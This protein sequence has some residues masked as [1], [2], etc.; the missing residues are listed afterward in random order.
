M[1]ASGSTVLTEK[2]PGRI[3]GPTAIKAATLFWTAPLGASAAALAEELRRLRNV[4][5]VGIVDRDGKALGIVR[6]GELFGLLSKPFGR[7]ILGRMPVGELMEPSRCFEATAGLFEVA[8]GLLDAD[9]AEK[10]KFCLLVD[11][12]GAFEGVLSAKDLSAYLAG[13]TREDIGLAEIG[14]AHV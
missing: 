4:D 5:A 11:G 12:S 13:M 14:R 2:K 3:Y 8:N 6:T 9:S 1:E 7:E 10:E